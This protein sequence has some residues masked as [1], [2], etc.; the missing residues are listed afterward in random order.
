MATKDN[1]KWIKATRRRTKSEREREGEF[2][3][4]ILKNST[5]GSEEVEEEEEDKI[6]KKKSMKWK[7]DKKKNLLT[8]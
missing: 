5:I 7:K 3:I 8:R 1:Q 4:P 6:V 2:F